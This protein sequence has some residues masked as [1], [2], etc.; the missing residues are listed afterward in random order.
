MRFVEAGHSQW[1]ARGRSSRGYPYEVA[2]TVGP[3][4]PLVMF[5]E[6]SGYTGGGGYFTVED[7]VSGRWDAHLDQAGAT[8]LKPFLER[9]AAGD[10]VAEAEIV[11]AFV[12]IHGRRPVISQRTVWSVRLPGGGDAKVAD[13]SD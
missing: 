3:P 13:L 11:R 4:C 2:V 5:A 8:W 7:A 12:A 6:G 10:E 1:T 9:M